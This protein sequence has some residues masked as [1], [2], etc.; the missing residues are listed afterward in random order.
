MNQSNTHDLTRLAGLVD[1]VDGWDFGGRCWAAATAAAGTPPDCSR[2][3]PSPDTS[4]ANGSGTHAA[5]LVAGEPSDISRTAGVAPGVRIMPLRIADCHS[6]RMWAS[7][8]LQAMAYALQQRASVILLPWVDD[9]DASNF[10]AW[11]AGGS[12]GAGNDTAG[13]VGGGARWQLFADAITP[14]Q[15]VGMLVV[16][17]DVLPSSSSGSGSGS[18]SSNSSDLGRLPCALSTSFDNMLC[19]GSSGSGEPSTSSS[20]SNAADLTLPGTNLAGAYVG[21]SHAEASGA[22]SS[23]ALGAGAAALVW[24]ALG[25]RLGGDYRGLGQMVKRVLLQPASVEGEAAAGKGAEGAGGGA[26]VARGQELQLVRAVVSAGRGDVGGFDLL[27]E[28]LLSADASSDQGM[29]AWMEAVS[30]AGNGSSISSSMNGSSR[31]SNSSAASTATAAPVDVTVAFP[32]A[33]LSWHVNGYGATN[34]AMLQGVLHRVQQ[35]PAIEEWEYAAKGDTV[36]TVVISG[37]LAVAQ[38]GG[39]GYALRVESADPFAL[40]AAGRRVMLVEDPKGGGAAGAAAD[41]GWVAPVTFREAGEPRCRFWGVGVLGCSIAGWT[42]TEGCWR[43][44]G[45]RCMALSL[46]VTAGCAALHGMVMFVA[47]CKCI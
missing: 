36:L 34:T 16:A 3:H 22:S 8:A 25:K 14:L 29:T 32:G 11:V 26:G 27:P 31:N 33:I 10:A 20:S 9:N 15:R 2:C 45:G 7:H 13:D 41:G 5:S 40:W 28:Y 46:S 21:A 35:A 23:A 17:A 47:P 4:D 6:G 37:Q 39:G 1:D 24:S 30:I 18:S 19:I 12:G 42:G 44:G 43:V 38:A